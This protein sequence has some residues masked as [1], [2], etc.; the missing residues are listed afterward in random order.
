MYLMETSTNLYTTLHLRE[1]FCLSSQGAQAKS[2]FCFYFT[3]LLT[4]SIAPYIYIS[5]YHS[6]LLKSF[7]LLILLS[8]VFAISPCFVSLANLIRMLSKS[9]SKS[10]MKILRGTEMRLD[11]C[12]KLPESPSKLICIH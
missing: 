5:A 8:A 4:S 9:S 3:S 7:W 10:L 12:E 1:I 11:Y 6:N 2:D